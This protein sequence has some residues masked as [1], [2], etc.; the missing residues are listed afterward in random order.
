M[1]KE[2]SIWAK[3]LK[4]LGETPE[5]YIKRNGTA[6]TD[7]EIARILTLNG[8]TTTAMA[9]RAKRSRMG[10]MVKLQGK[11]SVKVPVY[12]ESIVTSG[13]EKHFELDNSRIQS[14]EEFV[15]KYKIDLQEWDVA[16]FRISYHEVAHSEKAIGES[17]NWSRENG[18]MDVEVLTHIK[19]ILKPKS[20]VRTAKREFANL[21]DNAL[22]YAPKIKAI[23]YKLPKAGHLLEPCIVDHHFGRESW[24]EETGYDD[25]D[26]K[27]ANKLFDGAIEDLLVKTS[28]FQ[29]DKVVF[30]IGHDLFN[31]D[32]REGTTTGGTPQDNDTRYQKVFR[33][34]EE[35]MFRAV[36]RLLSVAPVDVVVV[37]GN[38]DTLTTWL[39]G[40][41]L[42]WKY[43]NHKHVTI[44]NQPIPRKYYEYG[45][46]MLMFLHGDKGKRLEYPALMASEMPEM[47]GRTTFH[48]IHTGD[49]HQVRLEEKYGVRTRILPSLVAPDYWTSN[50]AFL[51]SVRSSEAYVWHKEEG[52]ACLATH[53]I[54]T[55]AVK[56]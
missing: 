34:V 36:D 18:D 31:S 44:N 12:K 29:F 14:Q 28:A 23:K 2:H 25:Y 8:F 35:A 6:M 52:M 49:K 20:D 16:E 11:H 42:R 7:A 9:V 38:H 40:E 53:T 27:I 55:R 56:Q 26:L 4:K 54:P 10:G 47:W 39:L 24:G 41:V 50:N 15:K 43:A 32:N 19:A 30:P 51:G 22:K 45:Q 1:N 13:E 21:V 37:P 3:K 33:V 46:V 17:T 5:A 48:E